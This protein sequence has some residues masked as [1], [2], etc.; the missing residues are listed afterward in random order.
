MYIQIIVA[1]LMVFLMAQFVVSMLQKHKDIYKY[2]DT[3][4]SFCAYKNGWENRFLLIF[5]LVVSSNL[6]CM[7][8]EEFNRRDWD[9]TDAEHADFLIIFLVE[10]ACILVFPLVG[11]FYTEG[12]H[13]DPQLRNDNFECPYGNCNIKTSEKLHRCGAYMFLLGL[14]YTSIFWGGYFVRVFADTSNY[15]LGL[16]SLVWSVLQAVGGLVFVALQAVLGRNYRV[17]E[18]WQ[19]GQ[20]FR[21]LTQLDLELSDVD[22]LKSLSDAGQG[23]L[24]KEN[25][26]TPTGNVFELIG[27]QQTKYRLVATRLRYLSFVVEGVT[28]ASVIVLATMNTM[29]RLWFDSHDY[30]L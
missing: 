19:T 4:S 24:Q 15:A 14:C 5:T 22:V 18:A 20:M 28:A 8:F 13:P 21:Q 11:I 23:N 12:K 10:C 27:E 25:S 30:G 9:I 2:Y 6:L 16:F 3:I 29:I 26:P 7:H 17:K 1:A